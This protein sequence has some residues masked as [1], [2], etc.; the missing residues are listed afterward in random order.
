MIIKTQTKLIKK[1]DL[2]ISPIPT[3]FD[4]NMMA[5]GAVAAG[6]IKAQLAA[7]VAGIIRERGGI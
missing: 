5:F 4:P 1:P 7:R 2:I 6:N 3:L